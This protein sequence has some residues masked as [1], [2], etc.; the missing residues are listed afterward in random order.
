MNRDTGDRVESEEERSIESV[1][2]LRD[3]I[4]D[5]IDETEEI[6]R[7]PAEPE[8]PDVLSNNTASVPAQRMRDRSDGKRHRPF[9]SVCHAPKCISAYCARTISGV[10]HCASAHNN[11]ETETI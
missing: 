2:L 6:R 1:D 8:N 3:D 4:S 7:R 11:F 10:M 5:L 9:C